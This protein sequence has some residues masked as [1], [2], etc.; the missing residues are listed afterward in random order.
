MARGQVGN[1]FGNEEWRYL[2]RAAVEIG[3]MGGL[4]CINAAQADADN[5]SS[6][7]RLRGVDFDGAVAH[8]HLSRGEA[9]LN[10]E[11]HLF[12]LFGFDKIL[13]AKI[14]NLTSDAAGEEF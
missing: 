7:R 13:R 1:H 11:I 6:A 8:R 9:V 12:D 4:D 3:S 10:K 14:R 2:A 5:H